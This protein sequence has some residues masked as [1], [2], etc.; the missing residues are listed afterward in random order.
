[1]TTKLSSKGQIVLPA[2]LRRK[3][4]W[5]AGDALDITLEEGG[6]GARVVIASRQK[7]GGK[8]KIVTDPI[9]QLPA[10]KGPPGTPKLTS[11]MVKE[12]LADFP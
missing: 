8:W 7:R 5:Q 2:S 10:L 6:K 9:T 3:L 11:Q 4:A 12:M 1:V